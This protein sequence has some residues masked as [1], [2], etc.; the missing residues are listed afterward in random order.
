MA[1]SMNL[2]GGNAVLWHHKHNVY[3]HT[4]TNIEG[5]DEDIDLKPLL[6]TNIYQ[7]KLWIHRF[8]HV[9]LFI[10]YGLTYIFMS[11]FRDFKKYSKGKI[12]DNMPMPKLTTSEHF[13][14]WISKIVHLTLF[15][16]IP[17]IVLGP[18]MGFVGYV[19][20]VF[21]A[22]LVLAIVFQGNA[23]RIAGRH[24]RPLPAPTRDPTRTTALG[25]AS[26]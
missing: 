6:R 8:Q 2:L 15:L 13:V 12:G 22:G 1:H 18:V 23:S 24:G 10:L 4:Y 16:V 21:A 5:V 19:I 14:F 11:F 20:T 7:K 3:H 9:Y 17:M 26:P 25:A